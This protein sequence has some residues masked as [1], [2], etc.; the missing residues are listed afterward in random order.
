MS[1]DCTA[2]RLPLLGVFRGCVR[3]SPKAAALRA[4]ILRSK[5]ENQWPQQQQYRRKHRQCFPAATP[6]LRAHDVGTAI[7]TTL[8]LFRVMDLGRVIVRE[9]AGSN[10]QQLQSRID[11]GRS[12]LQAN[13]L[14][15]SGPL[16][17]DAG[18]VL[19]GNRRVDSF[20]GQQ[21]LRKL[22][23]NQVRIRCDGLH[24]VI[25]IN[26]VTP[27]PSLRRRSPRP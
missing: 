27:P 21:R 23:R 6:P 7:G 4:F 13:T 26:I 25:S 10:A 24:A 19:L 14:Q 5:C 3:F 1:D 20:S 15:S 8:L 17:I 12:H 22:C 2:E 16:P 11:V 9:Q 18:N